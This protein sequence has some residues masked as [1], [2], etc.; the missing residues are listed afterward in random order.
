MLDRF[1]DAAYYGFKVYLV[2]VN[3]PWEICIWRNRGRH[4][5]GN[6]A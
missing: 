2:Y 1:E 4:M 3:V 5:A 6:A